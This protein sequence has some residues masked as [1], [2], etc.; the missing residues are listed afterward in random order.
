MTNQDSNENKA[1]D[2]NSQ[3]YELAEAGRWQ[4]AIPYYQEALRLN[5]RNVHSL[6]NMGNA[7]RALGRLSEALTYQDKALA[8][9]PD[10]ALAWANKAVVLSGLDRRPEAISCYDRSLKIDPSNK[11]TWFNKGV[12][13][14]LLGKKSEAIQCLDYIL[15]NLDSRMKNALGA[16]AEILE[17]DGRTNEA[18]ECRERMKEIDAEGEPFSFASSPWARISVSGAEVDARKMLRGFEATLR[19]R[20]GLPQIDA[21]FLPTGRIFEGTSV[22]Y[23]TNHGYRIHLQLGTLLGSDAGN[24]VDEIVA[25][26]QDHARKMGIRP[27]PPPIPGTEASIQRD[28]NFDVRANYYDALAHDGGCVLAFYREKQGDKGV[29]LRDVPPIGIVHYRFLRKADYSQLMRDAAEHCPDFLDLSYLE[30]EDMHEDTLRMFLREHDL[31][32]W[33]SKKF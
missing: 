8:V 3:G 9:D 5:P 31:Y 7:L 2:L 14:F 15:E 32:G 22:V 30:G 13:L 6:T 20:T 19:Q 11:V 28:L 12:A 4:E 27:V 29:L 24:M 21:S 25:F 17:G 1:S 18:A 10:N 23:S 26:I 16:K 33:G